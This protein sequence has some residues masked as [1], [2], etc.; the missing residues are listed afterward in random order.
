MTADLAD[1]ELSRA[2]AQPLAPLPYA[3]HAAIEPPRV[4]ENLVPFPDA[5]TAAAAVRAMR[6]G[7][8]EPSVSAS[9]AGRVSG[10]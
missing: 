4:V 8:L 5:G 1:G 3:G 7:E 9:A 6:D 2:G 10:A